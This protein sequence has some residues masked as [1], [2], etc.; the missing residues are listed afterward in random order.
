MVIERRR[1][2]RQERGMLKAIRVLP[3]LVG[4]SACSDPVGVDGSQIAV[5]VLDG[6]AYGPANIEPGDVVGG[7][8][9][10]VKR[11]IDCSRGRWLSRNVH[12]EDHCPLEEGESNFLDGGTAIHR[13]E[14]AQPHERLAYFSE[15]LWEWRALVPYIDCGSRSRPESTGTLTSPRCD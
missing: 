1:I 10:T 7:V 2:R 12:V 13:I 14:G 15:F 11:R 6:V 5:V 9:T 4:L 8:H 3:L